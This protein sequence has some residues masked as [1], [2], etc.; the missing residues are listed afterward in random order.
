M[1]DSQNETDETIIFQEGGG[2]ASTQ[3]GVAV[4]IVSS[5]DKE[6][7]L[8]RRIDTPLFPKKWQIVNGRLR[9]NEQSSEAAL[10]VIERETGMKLGTEKRLHAVDPISLSEINCFYYVYLLALKN[11]ETPD[12]KEN[13]FRSEW[14]KFKL[15]NAVVLD[16]IPGTRSIINHLLKSYMKYNIEKSKKIQRLPT[17]DNYERYT[18]PIGDCGNSNNGYVDEQIQLSMFRT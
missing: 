3:Y 15:G 13:K 2:M 5:E 16:L 8:S 9:V 11:G 10:R 12:L 14:R 7:Y 17:T 4:A 1:T 18:K 6:V